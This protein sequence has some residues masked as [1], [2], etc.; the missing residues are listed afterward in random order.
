MGILVGVWLSKLDFGLFLLRGSGTWNNCFKNF[1]GFIFNVINENRWGWRGISTSSSTMRHNFRL[2]G[3]GDK[4]QGIHRTFDPC[5]CR[6]VN[7]ATCKG[8]QKAVV[9]STATWCRVFLCCWSFVKV[10]A[11]HHFIVKACYKFTAQTFL[12]AKVPEKNRF[13]LPLV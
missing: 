2:P 7:Y 3:E 6:V 10:P 13:M 12:L 1:A 11:F 9:L 4:S 8:R 5:D